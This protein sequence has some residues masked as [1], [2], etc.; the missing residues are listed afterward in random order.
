MEFFYRERSQVDLEIQY[1]VGADH[2]LAVMSSIGMCP[3]QPV[4]VLVVH[5]NAVLPVRVLSRSTKT[6]P[7]YGWV[8]TGIQRRV[9]SHRFLS[10]APPF[11]NGTPLAAF[12][13]DY[14][15]GIFSV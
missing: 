8:V 1:V 13:I 15:S 6:Q 3:F 7:K 11:R 4:F 14:Y 10:L 5:E 9:M 2:C 12:P